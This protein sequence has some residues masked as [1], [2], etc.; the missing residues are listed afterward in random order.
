M[1][2]HQSRS[3]SGSWRYAVAVLV[4]VLSHLGLGAA[5]E[6]R[7]CATARYAH[8]PRTFVATDISNEPD[9]Q[10]SLVRL[11]TYA[12]ELD[13]RGLAVTTSVW[14]NDSIDVPTVHAVLDGY[15]KV[16]ANLNAHVPAAA[17]YPD[18]D[19]LK[20][21]VYPGHPVYGLA[22]LQLEPSDAARALVEA[23]DAADP[24]DDPLYVCLWGGAAVLAEALQHVTRTRSAAEAAAFV[25]RLRVYAISDQDDAGAWVR[26]RFPGLF[27]VVSLHGFSEYTQ[28][29]WNG[30]SGEAYRHFDAGGPDS[31]LVTNDW[32]QTHIRVGALGREH[33]PRFEFIM[34]GDTPSFFPL[35]PNGL[36]DPRHP[37]WG[38]WGGRFRLVDA[39][40]RSPVY[41]DVGDVAVGV[42]GNVHVSAFATIWRWRPAYQF[43]FAARMRW[44]LGADYAGA[45][46]APVAVV[47]GTCGPAALA[48]DYQANGSVVVD[49]AA[50]WDPDGDQLRFAWFHYREVVQRIEEGEIDPVSRDVHVARLNEAGS[51]VRITPLLNITMHIILSVEDERDMGLTTY[52]R[53]ILNPTA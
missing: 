2:P 1:A 21:R 40:G 24:D 35:I 39:S 30:I 44:T 17:P 20:A 8:R 28:A 46:H 22:A 47:N 48:V 32:L 6:A 43:D 53:I 42:D 45:N 49:A 9:D 16:R 34:E 31:A 5:I 25:A 36:G 27:Y 11:L 18:A 37:E 7:Q 33:Y 3:S 19:V 12:N 10:M 4:G 41:S 23:A 29:S 26:A 51:V 50:S 13:V 15:A 38:S 52:R 14:K